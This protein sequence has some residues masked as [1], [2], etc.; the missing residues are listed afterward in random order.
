MLQTADGSSFAVQK[1]L[2][3]NIGVEVDPGSILGSTEGVIHGGNITLDY[4][5]GYLRRGGLE[6]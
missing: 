1:F 5:C 2:N 6:I 3:K 4:E